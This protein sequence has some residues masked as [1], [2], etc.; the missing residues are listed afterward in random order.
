MKLDQLRAFIAVVES[1]SFRAAAEAIHKTQPSISA[2]VKALEAQYGLQLLDRDSYRPTL[3]AQGKAFFKQSK[4][5]LSQVN[6]LESLGHH[7]AQGEGQ[8]SLRLCISQMSLTDH[9]IGLLKSFEAAHPQ[10][11]IELTT[12]HLNGVQE[13]LIKEKSDIAIGPSY[14]LDD[15]H[16]F[17]EVGKLEMMSVV[18]PDLLPELQAGA[19][20]V[21]QQALYSL[22]QILV[23]RAAEDQAHRFVL[24]AGKRWHVNDFQAKKSLVQAGMGWAR[25]PYYMIKDSLDEGRLVRMDVENFTSHSQFPLFMIRLRNQT[26]SHEASQFWDHV[27]AAV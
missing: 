7:L 22:P 17:V 13:H 6:Q 27:K 26:L 8:Q 10:I 24:P 5:L 19:Q 12:D 15:R 21:K 23:S 9:I 4:K 18:H 2:A 11:T 20:K 1:G 25:M 14:G 16:I 3:T